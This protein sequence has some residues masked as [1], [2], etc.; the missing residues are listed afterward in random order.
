V[1]TFLFLSEIKDSILA[2]NISEKTVQDLEFP[3]VL[4]H[5]AEYCISE[6]GKTNVLDIKPIEKTETLQQELNLV[7]EYLSSFISENR[8]PNHGFENISQEIFTLNI[9]NS[10]LEANAFLKVVIIGQDPYHGVGQ[11]NGLCFSVHDSIKHP[12]SLVN[13]FKELNTDIQKEIPISGDLSHWANQGVLLL[14]ATLTVKAHEA[15]SHQKHGW[16]VFTDAVISIISEQ[17]RDVVFL[18]WGGFAQKKGKK[19]DKKKHYVLTSGHPSPLS[20]NRGYWFGNKHFSKT[21]ELLK[22]SRR[23]VIV[24]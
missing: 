22:A 23:P 6:L 21:N 16:E 11:A 10:F 5:V 13:I 7:N 9:E 15:G 14:N 18:L 1:H 2:K 19:I 24:W 20:A 17:K 12:P 8:I 3:T 4:E